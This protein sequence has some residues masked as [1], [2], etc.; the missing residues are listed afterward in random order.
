MLIISHC[1][2]FNHNSSVCKGYRLRVTIYNDQIK[3]LVSKSI[4][5]CTNRKLGIFKATMSTKGT[6]K[7]QAP[8]FR[9]KP[10]LE[11][12]PYLINYVLSFRK[13]NWVN[14]HQGLL[15]CVAKVSGSVTTVENK[16]FS[17]CRS[18][19]WSHKPS[20]LKWPGFHIYNF[21]PLFVSQILGRRLYQ[22]LSTEVP[23]TL[24]ITKYEST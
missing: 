13:L 12:F 19:R 22:A 2:L 21:H 24:F 6:D 3:R 20:S 4:V 18:G 9:C 8:L 10:I 5:P 15:E 17:F 1:V 23:S 11:N 16:K 14:Y 7:H